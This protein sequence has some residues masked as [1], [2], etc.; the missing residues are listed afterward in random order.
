MF[1]QFVGRSSSKIDFVLCPGVTNDVAAIAI[2]GKRNNGAREERQEDEDKALKRRR[3]RLMLTLQ[4]IN[5][6][7]LKTFVMQ[8]CS[9]PST[10]S[11][12]YSVLLLLN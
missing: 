11:T 4:S 1:T 5:W 10:T 6:T 9:S 7:R 12:N 8:L 2:S 3:R